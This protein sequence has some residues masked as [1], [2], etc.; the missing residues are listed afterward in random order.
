MVSCIKD[1]LEEAIEDQKMELLYPS[2]EYSE[3]E[4]VYLKGYIDGLSAAL[5]ELT[6]ENSVVFQINLN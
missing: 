2:R 3:G 6:D 1:K 5:E 4:K